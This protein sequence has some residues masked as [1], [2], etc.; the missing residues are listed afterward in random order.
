MH[1]MKCSLKASAWN[2]MAEVLSQSKPITAVILDIHIRIT[3]HV[4]DSY[5]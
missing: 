2:F 1:A 5:V 3:K 4:H